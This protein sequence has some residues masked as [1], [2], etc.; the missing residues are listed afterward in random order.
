MKAS[1]PPII[2]EQVLTIVPERVWNAITRLDEI[3]QWFFPQVK[4]FEPKVGFETA[5]TVQSG[6]RTFP[7]LWKVLQVVPIKKIVTEWR[8]GDYP[9]VSSVAFELEEI[10]EGTKFRLSATVLKDFPDNIPEFKRESGVAGWEYLIT[11]S[12]K[13]YL[14]GN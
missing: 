9:G 7:H 14:E 2:V 11:K 5:F 10:L 12:L 13:N 4:A 8:F 6:E 3:Q 1:E